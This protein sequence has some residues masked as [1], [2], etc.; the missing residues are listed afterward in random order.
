MGQ[1]IEVSDS[2]SRDFTE[3][4]RAVARDWRPDVV[5]VELERMAYHLDALAAP[6]R[7]GC[8]WP[9]EAAGR[10]ALDLRRAAR[11]AQRLVRALDLRAWRRY[12]PAALRR[13]DAV[14][15]Y[16]DRDRQRARLI[17]PEVPMV[18]IPLR[19]EVPERP[20]DP[21]GAVADRAVRRRVRPPAERGRRGAPRH[22]GTSPGSERAAPRHRCIWWAT[23][24]R[25]GCASSRA[26][27][28]W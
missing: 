21:L 26:T 7:F 18:T 23:S 14:V 15:C 6:T 5:H 10:T 20:L 27:T 24:P 22:R 12:E 4:V 19:V 3:R 16:T 25:R 2:S 1:P 17:A 13:V 8:S 9:I 11:G 28:S